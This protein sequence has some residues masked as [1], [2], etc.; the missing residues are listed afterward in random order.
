M[1]GFSRLFNTA[2][3]ARLNSSILFNKKVSE[4]VAINLN[5]QLIN[6]IRESHGRTMFIRPG[7]FYTKKYFDILVIIK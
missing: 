5:K 1:S 7:K 3:F 6:Q 4:S 2:N